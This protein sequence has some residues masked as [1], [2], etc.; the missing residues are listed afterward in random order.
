MWTSLI[1]QSSPTVLLLRSEVSGRQ[2]EEEKKGYEREGWDLCI[3]PLR[4]ASKEA[5]KSISRGFRVR[6][7]E[8]AF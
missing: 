7:W 4:G 8:P 2:G 6:S 3:A 5:A 1:L